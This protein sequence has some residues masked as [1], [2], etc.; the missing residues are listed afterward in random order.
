MNVVPTL[1]CKQ[2]CAFCVA[3]PYL[4]QFEKYGRLLDL[5]TF[6]KTLY[7]TNNIKD[8]VIVGGD[9][10]LTEDEYLNSLINICYDYLNKPVELFSNL[11]TPL[12]KIKDPKKVLLHVSYDP[13]DRK[14]TENIL[15]K[16]LCIKSQYDIRTVVTKNLINNYGMK[17]IDRLSKKLGVEIELQTYEISHYF[18]NDI[19]LR[20]SPKELANFVKEYISYNNTKIILK[21]ARNIYTPRTPESIYDNHVHIAPNGMFI[22]NASYF[23]PNPKF[24]PTYEEGLNDFKKRYSEPKVC[25]RCKY[26]K[27]CQKLY[28]ANTHECDYDKEFMEE[29]KWI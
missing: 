14:N 9:P 25:E 12:E 19:S 11:N 15:N 29:I 28:C 2:G 1:E 13:C 23:S 22:E 4:N 21:S 3:K 18:M 10:F 5:K 16:I 6:E 20:P 27:V 8:L 17:K 7:S 24:F 26:N